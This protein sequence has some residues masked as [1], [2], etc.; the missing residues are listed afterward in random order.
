MTKDVILYACEHELADIPVDLDVR[1]WLSEWWL[2]VSK[3]GWHARILLVEGKVISQGNA[4][5]RRVLTQAVA[6]VYSQRQGV[7]GN[8]ICGSRRKEAQRIG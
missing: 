3:G 4:L 8:R 2:P 1:E 5:N 6:E 7:I